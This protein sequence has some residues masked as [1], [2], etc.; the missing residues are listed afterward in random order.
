M[1]CLVWCRPAAVLLGQAGED[2]GQDGG[3]HARTHRDLAQR[4]DGEREIDTDRLVEQKAARE[5]ERCRAAQVQQ[6]AL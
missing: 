2:G 5:V 6:W 3:Q 4:V 1:S